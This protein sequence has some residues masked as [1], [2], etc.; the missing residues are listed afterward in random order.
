MIHSSV[1]SDAEKMDCN[2]EEDIV[3]G[4]FWRVEGACCDNS[5]A[6]FGDRWLGGW[7]RDGA[8]VTTVLNYNR[9]G[10]TVGDWRTGEARA[11][12]MSN[13]SQ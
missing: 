6:S 1:L 8:I 4:E 2:A 12:S 13:W 5:R 3:L 7:S 11:Q 10:S 9:A